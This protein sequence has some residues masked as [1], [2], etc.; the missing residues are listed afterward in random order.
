[1]LK[2]YT[3]TKKRSVEKKDVKFTMGIHMITNKICNASIYFLK[4]ID[5]NTS[6]NKNI[7]VVGLYGILSK[8]A[9]LGANICEAGNCCYWTSQAF[10]KNN[11]LTSHSNFPMVFFYKVLINLIFG[12]SDYFLK[13]KNKD[14]INKI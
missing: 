13:N 10:K 12:K 7:L 1:M 5:E 14:Y 2:Y 6:Q 4:K 11:M 9:G 8:L 3:D